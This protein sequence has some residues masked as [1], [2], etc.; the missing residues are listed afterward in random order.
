MGG[1]ECQWIHCPPILQNHPTSGSG[2]TSQRIAIH[3]NVNQSPCQK[4]KGLTLPPD[5][6]LCSTVTFVSSRSAFFFKNA[7]FSNCAKY[8]VSHFCRSHSTVGP[9]YSVVKSWSFPERYIE[10]Y[11]SVSMWH[12]KRSL[13]EDDPIKIRPF[14]LFIIR[15][16]RLVSASSIPVEMVM[17][18]EYSVITTNCVANGRTGRAIL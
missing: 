9:H 16:N 8:N 2:F 15:G 12:L 7:G 5:K 11:R 1:C 14:L 3:L 6:L 18:T 4:I 13:I 10:N 17:R